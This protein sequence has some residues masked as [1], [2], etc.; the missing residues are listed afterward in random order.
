MPRFS[1]PGDVPDSFASPSSVREKPFVQFDLRFTDR[2]SCVASSE[3]E[4]G[5][6]RSASTPCYNNFVCTVHETPLYQCIVSRGTLIVNLTTVP[7]SVL[8]ENNALA[9]AWLTYGSPM[10]WSIPKH[11]R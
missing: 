2:L 8:L 4:D 1:S 7:T 9:S 5:P 3:P 11:C 10:R 6:G